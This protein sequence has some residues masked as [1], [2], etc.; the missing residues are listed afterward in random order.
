MSILLNGPPRINLGLEPENLPPGFDE[1]SLATQEGAERVDFLDVYFLIDTSG[2]MRNAL[3]NVAAA[4]K[5]I[6]F[7]IPR[8]LAFIQT[9]SVNGPAPNTFYG[10]GWYKDFTPEDTCFS[11]VLPLTHWTESNIGSGIFDLAITTLVSSAGGGGDKP[12][13]QIFA[14]NTLATQPGI[15]WRNQ[16]LGFFGRRIV[17]WA[18][19]APGHDPSGGVTTLEAIFNLNTIKINVDAISVGGNGLNEPL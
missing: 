16:T 18:G 1:F 10:M 4:L 2:S 13:C 12:E 5:Q 9:G 11:N 15:G 7:G 6:M 17:A 3:G 8:L 14:L 19:D